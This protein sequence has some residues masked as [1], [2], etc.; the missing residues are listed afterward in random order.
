[1]DHIDFV[2]EC[3]ISPELQA[4]IDRCVARAAERLKAK[5]AAKMAKP[6]AEIIE[7]SSYRLRRQLEASLE[8]LKGRKAE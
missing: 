2:C 1:M 6:E 4:D 3:E 5:L 8:A 7:L